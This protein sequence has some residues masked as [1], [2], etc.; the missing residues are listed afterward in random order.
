MEDDNNRSLHDIFDLYI[1]GLELKIL[2]NI[3]VI[4]VKFDFIFENKSHSNN[5]NTH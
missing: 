5:F 4:I 3:N 2:L 1:K